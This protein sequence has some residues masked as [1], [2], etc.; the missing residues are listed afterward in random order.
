MAEERADALIE[1]GTYDVFEPACLRVG[2]AVVSGKSVLEEAF[3]QPMPA[4]D[5]S[6][7]LATHWRKLRLAVLQFDQMPLAHPAQGFRRGPV[8]QNGKTASRSR[9]LQRLD[10]RGLAFFAANPDLFKKVI[11]SNLIVG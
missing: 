10:I 8:V 2:L 7:A 1:F 3:G 11:E 6:S 4:Y 5:A 9:C